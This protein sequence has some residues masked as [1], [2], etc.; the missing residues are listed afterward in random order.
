MCSPTPAVAQ[1]DARGVLS[2]GTSTAG[3]PFVP[4]EQDRELYAA[5]S[6]IRYLVGSMR[7]RSFGEIWNPEREERLRSA[8]SVLPKL[9]WAAVAERVF[10]PSDSAPVPND[11]VNSCTQKWEG[12][13][14]NPP[15][16]TMEL[17]DL[18][19][20]ALKEGL[21]PAKILKDP[22]Y[23]AL[24]P[25]HRRGLNI[26]EKAPKFIARCQHKAQKPKQS[27]IQKGSRGGRTGKRGRGRG[28]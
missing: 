10:L 13:N 14:Y 12:L 6:S 4:A 17:E 9:S 24:M 1:A 23:D 18:L 11:P 25:F 22:A 16:W 20:K 3:S 19:C 21:T 26:K 15:A 27:I 28:R 7:G 2:R 5:S 8:K